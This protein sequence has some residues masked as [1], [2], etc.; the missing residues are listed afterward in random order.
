[1]PIRHATI[2]DV[3]E[4]ARIEGASY[5]AAEAASEERIRSR[6]AVYPDYFWLME[7][8]GSTKGFITG[9]DTDQE[10]LVNDM[11][12]DTSLHNPDGKWLLLFSVVT[13]PA[14]R[15][16]KVASRIMEKV[17]EDTKKREKTGVILTCKD[18]LR[19]FYSRFGFVDEGVSVSTHGGDKWYQMR[20][21]FS[22]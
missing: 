7:E 16:Q 2:N 15:H 3:P 19:D 20:L 5:P 1:M 8:D 14:F 17:L 22:R 6:V 10:I 21:V 9:L 18:K 13:D 4:L 12:A 11:Y